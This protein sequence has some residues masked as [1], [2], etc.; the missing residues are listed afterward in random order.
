[1]I[2]IEY[3]RQ[4]ERIPF[5][6]LLATGDITRQW[7][8]EAMYVVRSGMWLLSILTQKAEVIFTCYL[9]LKIWH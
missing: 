4:T 8:M 7:I 2:A 1:M 6:F 3:C 5:V 9:C